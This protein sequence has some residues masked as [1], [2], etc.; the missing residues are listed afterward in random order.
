M[1]AKEWGFKISDAVKKC[2]TL[3]ET[4]DYI[5]FWD[6]ERKNLPVATDGIVLKVND[7]TQQKNLGFTA[8]SPRWAIAYKFQVERALTRLNSVSYQVGRTGVI[9]PV[10]NLEPVQLSGTIV[11]RASLH[12][13]DIIENLDL[14]IGDMVYV[15]K[16]GEII[17][18]ITG[19]EVKER[20]FVNEKVVFLKNCPECGASLVRDRD[21]AAHYCP[22]EDNCPVQIKGKI[23]HFVARKAMNID[24]LGEETIALLFENNLVKN[25][26]D[27]YD[28]KKEDISPLERLGEK[29]AENIIF[30]INESKKIAFERVLFA[31]GIRFV[32]ETVA[33]RLT[34]AFGTI[35]N[36]MNA[37]IDDLLKVNDVGERIAQSV[38][39]YFQKEE[40]KVLIDRLKN[41]GLQFAAEVQEE[42]KSDKLAGKI[43]VISGTFLHHSR[44]EYKQIIEQ[45]GGVNSGSVSKKTSFI[46]A[47]E[48]IGPAKMG[49]AEQLGVK[50]VLEEEFLGEITNEE[51]RIKN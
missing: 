3:Q 15:E 48:N 36:L 47:G 44:D 42:Q 26:A 38:E 51:L 41:A 1:K 18:K 11:K 34:R 22:N 6:S 17:P 49:K 10:A 39:Q 35:E 16:G 5:N 31:L 40:H 14:Y 24:G 32:G 46:L 20:F 33:K 8:K 43:I 29:S 37:Q 23:E 19:V 28:L 25:V 7:L 21:E 45:H 27:I 2:C 30:S 12:N 13:A 9:T 50:L 4:L